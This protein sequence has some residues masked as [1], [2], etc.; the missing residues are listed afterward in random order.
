M[1]DWNS[2]NN[3]ASVAILKKN[4][5]GALLNSLGFDIDIVPGQTHY[6]SSCPIHGGDGDAFVL[7][8]EGDTLPIR[9]RCFSEHCD[10]KFKPSLLGLVRGLLSTRSGKDVSAQVAVEYLKKFLGHDFPAL[11][12]K[13]QLL[14]KPTPKPNL[15]SLSRPQVRKLLGIPSPTSSSVDSHPPSSTPLMSDT[16]R[17]SIEVWSR[18]TTTMAR[19]ALAIWPGP[20]SRNARLAANITIQRPNADTVNPNGSCCPASPRARTCTTITPFVVLIPPISS[21]SKVQARS[22]D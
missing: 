9:W 14:A 1:I 10:A 22:S 19:S 16:P 11:G 13:D 3:K 7:T 21:L 4:R 2:I 17:S 15:L 12:G 5:V 18:S 8:L 20:K 6:R